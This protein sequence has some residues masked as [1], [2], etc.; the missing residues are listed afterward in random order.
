MKHIEEVCPG[1]NDPLLDDTFVGSLG[2]T[3]HGDFDYVEGVFSLGDWWDE[4]NPLTD[5]AGEIMHDTERDTGAFHVTRHFTAIRDS[6]LP[7]AL[8][9]SLQG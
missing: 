3:R 7:G 4:S 5:A 1:W 2:M 8:I 6:G 9:E